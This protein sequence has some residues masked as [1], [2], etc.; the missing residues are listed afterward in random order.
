[1]PDD[2]NIS[3]YRLDPEGR[4][5]WFRE[6][7]DVGTGG[8]GHAVIETS[9][10]SIVL[11][12]YCNA[13]AGGNLDI[14]VLKM[15]AFG[16][17]LWNKGFGGGNNDEAWD[18]IEAS[19]GNYVITGY[20]ED[21][22]DNEDVFLMKLD[23]TDGS[24]LLDRKYKGRNDLNERG[25]TLAE[26]S[27]DNNFLLSGFTDLA[28]DI[29][30]IYLLKIS[31]T[32]GDTIWTRELGSGTESVGFDIVE[33]KSAITGQPEGYAIAGYTGSN[34]NDILLVKT[35]LDGHQVAAAN[36]GGSGVD[37]G[38]ALIQ[39]T[40]GGFLIA[41]SDG[42]NGLI[43]LPTLVKTDA[44]GARVWSK[45]YGNENNATFITAQASASSEF[46]RFPGPSRRC[47]CCGSP[48]SASGRPSPRRTES[49]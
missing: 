28:A 37:R 49:R 12:G 22:S 44:S 23:A 32:S 6:D 11:A 30:F 33:S 39:T 47:P 40:D 15:D 16:Q 9:D 31:S 5:I 27:V 7:L 34:N 38:F 1:M 4:I 41:G 45:T 14:Y 10:G 18:V 2:N 43:A 24:V 29:T 26:S 46:R 17:I 48:G 3:L 35:D 36:Y 42:I 19:D 13:C 8:Q 20:Y 25:F 21:G